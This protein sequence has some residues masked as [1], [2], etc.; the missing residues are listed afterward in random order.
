[1]INSRSEDVFR[2]NQQ[3]LATYHNRTRCYYR[4]MSVSI[5]TNKNDIPKNKDPGLWRTIEDPRP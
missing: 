4:L 1:M 5:G 2:G 3:T